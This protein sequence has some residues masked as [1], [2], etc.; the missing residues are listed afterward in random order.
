[1][2]RP[3]KPVLTGIYRGGGNRF[4]WDFG[5]IPSPKRA[6]GL[7]HTTEHVPV[8]CDWCGLPFWPVMTVI[9][10]CCSASCREDF[11]AYLSDR[12]TRD[13]LMEEL[14]RTP[15]GPEDIATILA[16]VRARLT[17]EQQENDRLRGL[18]GKG[19]TI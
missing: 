1:M 17:E 4:E 8:V 19:S 6:G 11:S 10:G 12:K 16:E 13:A 2:E 14:Q 5:K 18:L 3:Q 15:L 9:Q 7:P